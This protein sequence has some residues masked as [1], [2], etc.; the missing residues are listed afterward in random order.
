MFISKIGLH[1][2]PR[3]KSTAGYKR[4]CPAFPLF[5]SLRFLQAVPGSLR[6]T[7]KGKEQV[8]VEKFTLG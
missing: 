5:S 7:G 2:S 3:A 4:M 1:P 8:G 6:S